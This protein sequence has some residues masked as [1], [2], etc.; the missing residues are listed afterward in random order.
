MQYENFEI[1]TIYY[2]GIKLFGMFDQDDNFVKLFGCENFEPDN[3]SE[4]YKHCIDY[5]IHK[6][7]FNRNNAIE[8]M[9]IWGNFEQSSVHGV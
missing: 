3:I 1:K 8:K 7:G 5:L 2:N 6:R 9:K 4:F